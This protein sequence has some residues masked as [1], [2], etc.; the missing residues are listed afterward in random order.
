MEYYSA[1]KKSELL[2]DTDN[3][4]EKSQKHYKKWN[5]LMTKGYI[6]CDSSV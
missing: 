3:N 2:T 4:A 1:I 6:L 5:K